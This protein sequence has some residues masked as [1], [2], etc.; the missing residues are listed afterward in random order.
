MPFLLISAVFLFLSSTPSA[1]NPPA[2][3]DGIGKSFA[4]CNGRAALGLYSSGKLVDTMR[5]TTAWIFGTDPVAGRGNKVFGYSRASIEKA[6][7]PLVGTPGESQ[8]KIHIYSTNPALDK[9]KTYSCAIT[10]SQWDKRATK[11]STQYGSA[12]CIV[13]VMEVQTDET[14]WKDHY[15]AGA[16]KLYV[17]AETDT[18]NAIAGEL[19]AALLTPQFPK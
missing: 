4:E 14:K 10:V 2:L 9:G 5:F 7:F 17:E 12:K 1:G 16:A 18:G 15:C 19:N 8:L 6:S 13:E 3:T 11:W